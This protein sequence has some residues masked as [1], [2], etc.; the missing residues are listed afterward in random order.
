MSEWRKVGTTE[1]RTVG[2]ADIVGSVVMNADVDAIYLSHTPRQFV[3]YLNGQGEPI[4]EYREDT[5][6]RP[7]PGES[8]E[9]VVARVERAV[10]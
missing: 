10:K 6:L 5:S 2:P 9:D 7:R 8:A 4:Q 1:Y 3:V